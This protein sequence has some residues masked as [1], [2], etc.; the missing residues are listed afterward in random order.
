MPS[1]EEGAREIRREYVFVPVTCAFTSAPCSISRSMSAMFGGTTGAGRRGQAGSAPAGSHARRNQERRETHRD[2]V[3]ISALVEK[4]SNHFHIAG[5]G[6]AHQRR[7]SGIVKLFD[8]TSAVASPAGAMHIEL[9]IEIDTGGQ[10][11]C[12]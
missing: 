12:G 1:V 4:D 10:Q 11:R 3:G 5:N 7:A 9:R 8:E 6:G 2:D